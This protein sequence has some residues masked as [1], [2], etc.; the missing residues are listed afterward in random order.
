MSA[1]E[2]DGQDSH[3]IVERIVACAT[4]LDCEIRT[5]RT[6][7]IRVHFVIDGISDHG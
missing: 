6:H 5:G 4:L 1:D 2:D 3:T 7:Q